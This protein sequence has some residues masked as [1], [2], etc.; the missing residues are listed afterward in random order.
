M[1]TALL[2]PSLFFSSSLSCD[3]LNLDFFSLMNLIE[4]Q[5][6]VCS[7]LHKFATLNPKPGSQEN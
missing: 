2:S 7:N 5:I 1:Q 3:L 4:V 6:F